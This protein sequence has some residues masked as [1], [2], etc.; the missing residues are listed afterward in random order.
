MRDKSLHTELDVEFYLETPALAVIPPIGE[1]ENG[2]RLW[3][4]WK[5]K[6][7]EQVEQQVEV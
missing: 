4:F 2:R 6:G 7:A 3:R 1:P 5:R